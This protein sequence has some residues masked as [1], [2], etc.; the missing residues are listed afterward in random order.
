MTFNDFSLLST[1]E[2]A[3]NYPLCRQKI[4][5]H[6]KLIGLLILSRLETN[7]MDNQNKLAYN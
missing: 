4:L 6:K 3:K 2:R 1:Y 5:W 7:E